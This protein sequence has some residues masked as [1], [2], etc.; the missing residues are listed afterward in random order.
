MSAVG[1]RNSPTIIPGTASLLTLPLDVVR[2]IFSKHLEPYE[3]LPLRYVNK[4]FKN[5]T[6]QSPRVKIRHTFAQ[7]TSKDIYEN[8]CKNAA[9]KGYLSLL[10]W[11]KK[12][13]YPFNSSIMYS[14]AH[15]GHLNVLNWLI[16]HAPESNY[17]SKKLIVGRAALGGHLVALKWLLG[18]GF[19]WG[20]NVTESAAEGGNLEVLKWLRDNGCPTDE[21]AF[22][23]AVRYDH[24]NILKYLHENNFK[25]LDK[26]PYYYAA[27]RGNLEM[28]KWLK[29]N[30]EYYFN[31][32]SVSHSAAKGGH[33]HIL[34]WLC[35]IK[36]M[37]C[38]P[39]Y[40]I[41]NFAAEGGQVEVLK[42]LHKKGYSLTK[43]TFATAAENG[44]L[45]VLIWLRE[46]SCPFDERAKRNAES[47][48]HT[49]VL[50]WLAA[51]GY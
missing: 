13:D 41:C 48:G 5:L 36:E 40:N 21:L 47:R 16:D 26:T 24:L 7:I 46:Q 35:E 44:Q 15:G 45:E 49:R 19:P 8:L 10:K 39:F 33:I 17:E 3:I 38:T 6:D 29:A 14:A 2:L 4:R 51:N 22:D 18:K 32:E 37:N 50:D 11:A 42:W 34:E 23:T 12:I 31:G 9:K 20:E 28:L 1:P 30:T 27:A 43:G 25:G